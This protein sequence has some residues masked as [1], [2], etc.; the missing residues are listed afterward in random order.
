MGMAVAAARHHES[1][2][3][4][5]HHLG[6]TFLYIGCGTCLVAYIDVLAIFHGEGF[7]YLIVFG[8]ENLAI[9]HKVGLTCC[10][11]FLG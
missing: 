3:D 6:L 1:L 2:A 9:D 7:H 8:S 4:V 11:L 5:V 10:G